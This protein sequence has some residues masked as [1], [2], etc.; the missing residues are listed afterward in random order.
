M[1]A[2]R[3]TQAT[4]V[5]AAPSHGAS[6][7]GGLRPLVTVLSWE[8]RRLA[9]TR[10]T[11]IIVAI[12]FVVTCLVE[13]AFRGATDYTISYA[14]GTARTFWI[15][16]GSN[17]GLFNTLPQSPG[18]V[19]GLYLPFLA[20]DGVA[21]D[22]KRRTHELLM[23]TSIPSR[24]YV[25]GRYLSALVLGVGLACVMLLALVSLAALRHL[26]QPDIYLTPDLPG[27]AT[28]WALIVL[29]PTVL[30]SSISFALGT[31][32]PRRTAIV[33]LAVMVAWFIS[34]Q[35]AGRVI[36]ACQQCAVASGEPVRLAAWDPTSLALMNLQAPA[37]LSRHLAG[38]TQ[39]LSDRAFLEYLH[40][41]EQ[42]LPDMS[43][44]LVPHVVWALVGIA[45]VLLATPAFRRFRNALS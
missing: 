26:A 29:P 4:H 40:A 9:A 37:S 45:I 12:V 6:P 35:I 32:L 24:A 5:D 1:K 7:A 42:Q 20:A 33:K 11:W 39:A 38:Q 17:Y 36:T 8:L 14:N 21:R 13:L 10:S 31:A 41:L 2:M 15:D 44:W 25:W 19:L 34:A 3:P 16:W 22:L 18:V 30:L 43:P 27:I 23:T 28:L